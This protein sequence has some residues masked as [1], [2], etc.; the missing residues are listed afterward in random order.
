M[1][2]G[3]GKNLASSLEEIVASCNDWRGCLDEEDFA[4]FYVHN[5][6]T[7]H[8]LVSLFEKLDPS[9]PECEVSQEG[10]EEW[11]VADKRIA[12]TYHN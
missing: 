11:I 3:E 12:V 1:E 4:G 10:V 9:N 8:E 7:V 5:K 6:D 2:F